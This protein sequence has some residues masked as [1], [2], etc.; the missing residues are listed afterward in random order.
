MVW[1]GLSMRFQKLLEKNPDGTFT[2]RLVESGYKLDF[3][4]KASKNWTIDGD[5][6]SYALEAKTYNDLVTRHAESKQNFYALPKILILLCLPDESC[7]WMSVDHTCLTLR[8]CCYW[9]AIESGEETENTSS[10]TIKIPREN[11]LNPEKLN[12]LVNKCKVGGI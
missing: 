4:L 9:Y 3:Q 11:I 6:I 2:T 1:M 12:E 7:D 5:F 8:D 10:I